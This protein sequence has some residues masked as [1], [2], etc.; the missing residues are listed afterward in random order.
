MA[1]LN[2]NSAKINQQ[3]VEVE[4]ST[5]LNIEAVQQ[6]ECL[7]NLLA[8]LDLID[9]ES[10][11]AQES[12]ISKQHS[13]D[14]EKQID[15]HPPQSDAEQ[16]DDLENQVIKKQPSQNQYDV[17]EVEG[18]STDNQQEISGEEVLLLPQKLSELDLEKTS[19]YH[20]EDDADADAI[21]ALQNILLGSQV[22]RLVRKLNTDLKQKRFNYQQHID[23]YIVEPLFAEFLLNNF[24][25]TDEEVIETIT[26]VID[27]AIQKKFRQ[28]RQAITLTFAPLLPPAI[29][30]QIKQ[31]PQAMAEVLAPIIDVIIQK[32]TQQD[33]QSMSETLAPL[34]PG[35]ISSAVQK[36]PLE[37]AKALAPEMGAAIREQIK[38]DRRQITQALA[39]EMGRAIK[40]QIAL[41]QNA[42]VDALYPV[43]GST[44]SKYMAE[45]IREINDKISDTFSFR[46]IQRK[47]QAT[48]Q[49]V[50]EAE[51]IIS[52]VM[53]FRVQ[54][55]F[56]IHKESGLVISEAQQSGTEKLES[57][58]VAGMLTAI[59]SFV[60]DCIMQS[61]NVSEL[62][63]IEYGD[64]KIILEVAGHCYL[65]VVIRGE[66]NKSF[67][68]E[69]R[70][71]LSN[72]IIDYGK[73]IRDFDG[74]PDTI[75]TSIQLLLK[76]LIDIDI[77]IN[78]HH[79]SK[80]QEEQNKLQI[81]QAPPTALIIL[82]GLIISLILIPWG[83]YQYY[84]RIY[85]S[86][87]VRT[88]EA[89]SSVPELALYRL[90]AKV[91]RGSLTLTGQLPNQYLTNQAAAI[92]LQEA[93]SYNLELNNQIVAVEVPPE[94]EEVVGE[95]DR[96]TRALNQMEGVSIASEYAEG[97]VTLQ[98]TVMDMEDTQTVIRKIEQVPGVKSVISTIKISPLKLKTRIYFDLG[99][100]RLEPAYQETMV[101][102]AEF[103]SQ[104]PKK[105]LRIVGHTDRT[106]NQATNEKL[107][108]ERANAVMDA[109]VE[110][111]VDARRLEVTGE[112]N[113]P[114]DVEYNQPL[115]LSR[116]VTFE[117]FEP[118]AKDD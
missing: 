19:G 13:E 85:R 36:Y 102:I 117:L 33:Q 42:I 20:Q 75:P 96:I 15:Y 56:L 69:L 29:E 90:N 30:Q 95:L 22:A 73:S 109:L 62:N 6:L 60:N 98:G 99:M 80:N 61:G 54:A 63:Q 66:P 86:V 1:Y 89:W 92:A 40:E 53:V 64:S 65:A 105:H 28:D 18:I 23:N 47:I 87:E 45:A 97:K 100:S 93:S 82:S 115:L 79:L 24:A 48:F 104:Y 59:R 26:P 70:Q 3:E 21:S 107:A 58:M 25:Q 88:M 77:N 113:S 106:G 31:E 5:E 32:K 49:G 91:K 44:I 35:A 68:K 112:T 74:D 114:Q 12:I 38:I 67:I 81:S 7:L 34:L 11:S 46:G 2:G 9:F 103:L 27:Q 37:I 111:G 72:I 39:P 78:K 55:V 118:S 10:N 16:N 43:I 57:E 8:D 94:T 17:I 110:Q 50:S 52:E 84:S 116:C 83:I 14:W 76:G 51:L 41:E 71:I 108:I 4:Q 101:Q